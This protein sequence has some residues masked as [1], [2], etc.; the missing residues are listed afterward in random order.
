[1]QFPLF[2]DPLDPR[3]QWLEAI[4]QPKISDWSAL[5][6]KCDKES[7][8]LEIDFG[9]KGPSCVHFLRSNPSEHSEYKLSCGAQNTLVVA[10]DERCSKVDFSK[11]FMA[12]TRMPEGFGIYQER[13]KNYWV[14]NERVFPELKAL[15]HLEATRVDSHELKSPDLTTWLASAKS[16]GAFYLLLKNKHPLDP[17]HDRWLIELKYFLERQKESSQLKL[18]L[19]LNNVKIP[20]NAR[21]DVIKLPLV[22]ID[23][24]YTEKLYSGAC[25][26][27]GRWIRARQVLANMELSTTQ[28]LELDCFVQI[29][30][31]L[32]QDP[33][34]SVT[35][36]ALPLVFSDTLAFPFL[37][38][39]DAMN[40]N[41]FQTL[42]P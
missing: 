23:H 28:R 40:P 9:P 24:R 36:L 32:S 4:S 39:E 12:H 13:K 16:G 42:S 20:P 33:S 17:S 7:G 5:N 11:A 3:L 41:R 6:F 21:F 34:L 31:D 18:G 27:L 19:S 14:P 22:K 15:P 1:M 2:T 30:A 25:E 10:G 35:K 8:S 37:S 26:Y 38:I 29:K